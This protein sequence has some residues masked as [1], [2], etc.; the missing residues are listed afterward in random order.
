MGKFVL[1]KPV[2]TIDGTDLTKRISAVTIDMPDDEVDVTAFGSDY[3]ETEMGMRDASIALTMFQDFAASSVD[4]VL[5]PLKKESK[6]FLIKVAT[7]EGEPATDKPVYLMAGKLFGY[8]P[9]AGGVGDASSTEP[10]IKNITNLGIERCKS[11]AEVEAA[12]T[13]LKA[14]IA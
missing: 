2:I 10:T 7:A 1:K 12:E 11:K 6:K 14:A 3:K 8:S 4:A 13:A 9:L 5:W